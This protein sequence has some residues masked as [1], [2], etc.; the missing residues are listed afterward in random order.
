[1]K[2]LVDPKSLVFVDGTEIDYRGGREDGGF[3]FRNP[4]ARRHCHCGGS[5]ST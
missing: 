4:N 2:L 3:V 5:F 1:V